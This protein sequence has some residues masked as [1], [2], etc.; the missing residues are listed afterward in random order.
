MPLLSYAE[1]HYRPR[2]MPSL[3]FRKQPE[4]I[5]DIPRRIDPGRPV[6]VFILVKDADRFPIVLE[7]IVVH[8]AYSGGIER[9]AQFPYG[10]QKI[11]SEL[12]WDSINIVPEHTGHA[13]ID[14]YV[15]C[16]LRGK[17]RIIRTDNYPGTSHA[18]FPV[19]IADAFLPGGEGW[20]HGDI[21][22]HS[23]YT[24]DQVEFGAPLEMTAFAAYCMGLNWIAATDHSYDL[25]NRWDSASEQDP[26]LQK[27]WLMRSDSE[28]FSHNMVIVPGEEVTCRTS[29]G[30]NC[31][32]LSLN[33]DSF[34]SGSGDSGEQGFGVP[35]QHSVGEAVSACTGS[36]GL[37]C[38]A[39]PFE[40]IPVS[41]RLILKRGPWTQKDLETPGICGM[42]FYN[43]ARDK[44]FRA[45]KEEWIQ[46]LLAGKK[47][48]A[49]G[50]SDSHGD[51]NRSRRIGMPL[52]SVTE[53]PEHTLGM[54][55]TVVHA[56]HQNRESILQGL[57]GGHAVV[58]DGPFIDLAVRDGANRCIP[59]DT[60]RSGNLTVEAA[61]RSSK[62]F[63]PIR[64]FRLMGGLAAE[65]RELVLANMQGG[66]EYDMDDRF[67]IETGNILYIR[68][69][70]ETVRGHICFTNPVWISR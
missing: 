45:G 43:G 50:G 61:C 13:L 39:H 62:E 48:H 51:L 7:S 44:G 14:V 64:I 2:Y 18:P 31:H 52:V 49:F 34:I 37:A 55:R 67:P 56:E 23:Y 38:A 69:E 63:S 21:H 40:R 6:P 10:N 65:K 33:A 58:T 8:I 5:S 11:E 12:W 9:I 15:Q 54:V 28:E 22:C 16:M 27:W 70:C 29:E 66:N 47:I 68:A 4:I 53:S 32:M 3:I 46:L 30:R 60:C 1:I 41:E 25:D 57:S 26:L 59:G 35:S 17:K 42:Q 20:H 36:G 24:A 19:E